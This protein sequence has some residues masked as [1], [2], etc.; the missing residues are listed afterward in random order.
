MPEMKAPR[1]CEIIGT[2]SVKASRLPMSGGSFE[3][4]LKQVLQHAHEKG[5]D[6]IEITE[7]KS[8]DF[9][10][11]H[12]NLTANLLRYADV[13]ETIPVTPI[14]FQAYLNTNRQ[15][16]DPIEGIWFSSEPSPHV[17]GI[18]KNNSKRGRDFV[19]F[20][21]NASNPIWNAGAKKIDIRR[22]SEPG[23]YVLTYYLE[24]FEPRKRWCFCA[25][26]KLSRLIF[27]KRTKIFSL[28]TSKNKCLFLKIKNFASARSNI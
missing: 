11:P 12:Y 26:A 25:K 9:A 17:I 22:G 16:L 23:S 19:G 4:G 5:A 2:V 14:K 18:I 8:P 1:L 15:N 24:D 3:D 7:V 10:N 28:P 20:I 27:Q 21:L 6:A 13:W